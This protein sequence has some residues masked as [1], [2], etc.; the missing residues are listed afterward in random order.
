VF[1]KK[2]VS[3]NQSLLKGIGHPKN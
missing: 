3:V 1:A 2:A